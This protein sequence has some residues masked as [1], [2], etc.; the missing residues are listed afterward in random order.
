[1]SGSFKA[2]DGLQG[3]KGNSH[4]EKEKTT[5]ISCL[6]KAAAL[7]NDSADGHA[8]RVCHRICGQI[9]NAYGGKT[10]QI[11]VTNNQSPEELIKAVKNRIVN[12]DTVIVA[13]KKEIVKG[14][15]EAL[16]TING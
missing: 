3:H 14:L 1:M 6:Q 2:R 4:R 16:A 15:D 11:T 10:P 8:K 9:K 12:D 5:L 7:L 13:A